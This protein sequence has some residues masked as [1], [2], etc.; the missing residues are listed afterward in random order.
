MQNIK[1]PREPDP[2]D[3]TSDLVASPAP[4]DAKAL[5]WYSGRDI[6]NYT[7]VERTAHSDFGIRNQDNALPNLAPHRHEYFQI[8][9]QIS[10]S[11]THH[12]GSAARPVTAGTICFILPYKVHFI[13]T[14][15]NSE[16]YII[17]ASQSFLMPGLDVDPLDLEDVSIEQAPELA[18]FKYQEYLDFIFEDD[19]LATLQRLCRSMLEESVDQRLG[20]T[21]LCRAYLHQCIGL[22]CRR[23]GPQLWHLAEQR[24]SKVARRE[25]LVGLTQFLR[26]NFDKQISLTAAAAAVN[27]S[28]TYLAH[29]IKKETGKTFLELL[30]ERRLERAKE[31][32]V[33]T[34]LP[35]ARVAEM[36]G[37]GDLA[38]FARRFRQR[39]G[40]SP[41]RFR[42]RQR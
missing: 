34:S 14:A 7:M 21:V 39:T 17:N 25:A 3:L 33:H 11:T 37:F 24:I 29:V 31:L 22:V 41:S 2:N 30:T 23:F 18:P 36:A 26:A 27:L 35:I 38:Y 13:P 32:I 42:A 5:L 19:E 10:G 8:H 9:A 16:Y 15:P 28:P 6:Q 12:I 40:I 1:G 4:N 20:T